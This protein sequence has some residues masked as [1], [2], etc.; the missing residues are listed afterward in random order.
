MKIFNP[1]MK[2]LDAI[3]SVIS[4]RNT[5]FY[6]VDMKKFSSINQFVLIIIMFIGGAPISNAGGI[7]VNVFAILILTAMANLKNREQVVIFYRSISDKIV[8]RCITIFIIDSLIVMI[9]SMLFTLTDGKDILDVLFYI[10]SSFSTT[11][12]STIDVSQ[13]SFAGKCVSIFIMYIG[14]IAPI[15]FVSLFIPMD[16][17]KSGI[18]YPNMD[19]IL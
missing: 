17:K 10:V 4:A 12:L 15:T 7:R 6:T 16:H 3:F 8:K 11:G 1:E 2:L 18:K 19:V 13:I 9:C 5:G 14:R